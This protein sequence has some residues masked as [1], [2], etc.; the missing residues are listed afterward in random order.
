LAR[1]ATKPTDAT[2]SVRGASGILM[3]M[4]E[5]PMQLNKKKD[6]NFLGSFIQYLKV[7]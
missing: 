4:T 5:F 2:S 3:M 6:S 7:I 1:Q